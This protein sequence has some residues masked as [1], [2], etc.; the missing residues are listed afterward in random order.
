MAPASSCQ[1]RGG[2]GWRAV[3]VVTVSVFS[4]VSVT[5]K[6]VPE[7]LTIHSTCSADEVA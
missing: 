2:W 6:R 1:T 7:S 5:T 4:A 3:P